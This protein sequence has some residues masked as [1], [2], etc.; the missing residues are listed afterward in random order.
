LI[1]YSS[2]ISFSVHPAHSTTHTEGYDA[3][4]SYPFFFYQ[5]P[6]LVPNL[7][8]AMGISPPNGV[9]RQAARFV[10][11]G[12]RLVASACYCGEKR[13]LFSQ[14]SAFDNGTPQPSFD[15]RTSVMSDA[16]GASLHHGS[17]TSLE[18]G[19]LPSV[20]T[21]TATGAANSNASKAAGQRVDQNENMSPPPL[22]PKARF[23][24]PVEAMERGEVHSPVH[25]P[26]HVP[27]PAERSAA[28]RILTPEEQAQ[29][30]KATTAT[31][32]HKGSSTT[33]SF[34]SHS[35]LGGQSLN[36]GTGGGSVG[37]SSPRRGKGAVAVSLRKNAARGTWEAH[38]VDVDAGSED[39]ESWNRERRDSAEIAE[40]IYRINSFSTA[41]ESDGAA[42][43][44]Y[45]SSSPVSSLTSNTRGS[46]VGSNTIH[47][48]RR[49]FI[50]NPNGTQKPN[51]NNSNNKKNPDFFEKKSKGWF[52]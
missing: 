6:E 20:V 9:L 31:A 22:S 25:A 35:S 11:Y 36:S 49:H 2:S 46:S 39:E 32:A 33:L 16:H 30:R 51:P 38:M 18:A 50:T 34:A 40:M 19:A 24:E 41:D 43:S 47:N 5:I 1:Y 37:S 23:Q 48:S 42:R 27:A 44:D 17:L 45:L 52:F 10:I 8:I 14:Q 29:Q 15:N 26:V 28:I 4:W 12:A 3:S 21:A 13:Y 7:V